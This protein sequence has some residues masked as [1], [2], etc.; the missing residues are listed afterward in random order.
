MK[1][2]SAEYQVLVTVLT[3]PTSC[4]SSSRKEEKCA[5]HSPAAYGIF[6]SRVGQWQP[7]VDSYRLSP[8]HFPE[9]GKTT[10][11]RAALSLASLQLR[12]ERY[13]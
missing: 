4:V 3:V 11:A 2:D 6:S 9:A 1:L 12:A 7:C 10:V 8:T 5:A 13:A